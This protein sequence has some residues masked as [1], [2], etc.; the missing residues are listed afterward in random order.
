R[1]RP[2]RAPPACAS[3][4]SDRAFS[5]YNALQTR[6]SARWSVLGSLAPINLFVVLRPHALDIAWR[7]V[8]W[9]TTQNPGDVSKCATHLHST[10]ADGE[11]AN[12][13]VVRGAAHLEHGQ[14]ALHLAEHLDIAEQNYRI[15]ESRDAG[16]RNRIATH[17]RAGSRG[18]HSRDLLVLDERRQPDHELAERLE[19]SNVLERRQTVE[20]DTFRPE[21]IDDSLDR[22]EP[23]LETGEIG[24][25]A[26]DAQ[27]SILLHLLE[28]ESP[29]SRVA[30]EL[31]PTLL[32]RE[33]QTLLAIRPA[34]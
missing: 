9:R 26:H 22:D 30:H 32:E 13:L 28:I 4:R 21:I 24:V 25:I 18:E 6:I 16:L 31:I 20:S 10:L 29:A 3:S 5:P 17:Q 23:V 15:G 2:G 27:H 11:L 34:A 33:Q 14:A 7:N 1:Q 19:S 8:H 12:G